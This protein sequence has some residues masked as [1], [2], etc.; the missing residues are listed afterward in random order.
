MPIILVCAA[1]VWALIAFSPTSALGLTLSRVLVEKPARWLSKLTFGRLVW[2]V[3][4]LFM[5]GG[6]LV[7]ART[8]AAFLLPQGLPEV[9]GWVATLDGASVV[10]A[11]ALAFVLAAG[12][13][14][15]AAK[16][17]TGAVVCRMGTRIGRAHR[18]PRRPR[19]PQTPA[20]EDEPAVFAFAA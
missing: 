13:G 10:D 17:A 3:L 1:L 4:I 6:V 19:K 18:A 9:V 7:V 2:T 15:R 12:V 11:L 14:L 8:E 5:I 16:A 20:N